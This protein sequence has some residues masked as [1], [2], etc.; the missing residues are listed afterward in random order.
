[1]RPIKTEHSL[2]AI[3]YFAHT[4]P[5]YEC[6][7]VLGGS[8]TLLLQC[9]CLKKCQ[10]YNKYTVMPACQP[11]RQTACSSVSLSGHQNKQK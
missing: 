1:M 7:C 9:V 4:T 5:K 6:V 3:V 10:T 2:V 11:V 8:Q